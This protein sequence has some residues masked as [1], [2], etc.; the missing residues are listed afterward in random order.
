MAISSTSELINA[1]DNQKMMEGRPF[2]TCIPPLLLLPSFLESPLQITPLS[3]PISTDIPMT[4]EHFVLLHWLSL[5][6]RQAI[7]DA[8]NNDSHVS[9]NTLATCGHRPYQ[10]LFE[11]Y[12]HN[13][14][15][16]S[17]KLYKSILDIQQIADYISTSF[18]SIRHTDL[19]INKS[20]RVLL[21][22]T[23]AIKIQTC[24]ESHL[25]YAISKVFSFLCSECPWS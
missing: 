9:S 14:Q 12:L 13:L 24:R 1:L 20:N 23:L 17:I 22:S 18:S 5:L 11:D 19:N 16:G 8:I 15:Q 10:K 4:K 6:L 7:C 21:N 2:P 3:I 25:S